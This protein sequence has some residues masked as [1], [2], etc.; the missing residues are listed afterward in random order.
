MDEI[1]PIIMENEKLDD[2]KLGTHPFDPAQYIYLIIYNILASSAFGKRYSMNDPEFLSVKEMTEKSINVNSNLTP[3]TI[4]AS[5]FPILRKISYFD[6]Q[7]NSIKQI[8]LDFKDFIRSNFENHLKDFDKNEIRDF[9]DALIDAR[10]EAEEEDKQTKE[11]LKNGNLILSL[12]NLFQAGSDTTHFTFRWM[13]LLMSNYTSVQN[14][15][16]AEINSIIGDRRPV[17]EDMK[18]CHYVRAFISECQRFRGI[19][20]FGTFHATICDTELCGYKIPKGTTVIPGQWIVSF[21]SKHWHQPETFEPERFFEADN[22]NDGKTRYVTT[23]PIAFIP[24][25]TGRRVCLG[26]KMALVD[27]FLILVRFIQLT[28]GYQVQPEDGPETADL[29][30]DPKI[31]LACFPKSFKIKLKKCN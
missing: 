28:D 23:K 3:A 26:E 5:L 9:T 18:S 17:Q 30:P 14:K 29:E 11:Y 16:R 10:I 6:K 7:I 4:L 8:L 12:F 21:S 25:G 19:T 20:P 22:E 31:T 27:L 13:L 2:G 24:F 1:V 15:L